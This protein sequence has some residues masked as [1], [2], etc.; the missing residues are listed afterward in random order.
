MLEQH[1]LYP[2]SGPQDVMHRRTILV[3]DILED[4]D[5]YIMVRGWVGSIADNYSLKFVK[6]DKVTKRMTIREEPFE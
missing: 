1:K 6:L 4:T 3:H 2:L 5:E